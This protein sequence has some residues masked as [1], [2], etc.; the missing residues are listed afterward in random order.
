[1]ICQSSIKLLHPLMV[2]SVVHSV[3]QPETSLVILQTQ[4]L[5]FPCST[6]NNLFP[7]MCLS[8]LPSL[9][10]TTCL[11]CLARL[12]SQPMYKTDMYKSKKNA[13]SSMSQ[14]L[15]CNQRRVAHFHQCIIQ[16]EST[17]YL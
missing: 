10:Y 17:A 16:H 5:C 7:T 11:W 12:L 1:M 2:H 15:T 8:S 9:P 13:L 4:Q 3:P 14:L 6:S